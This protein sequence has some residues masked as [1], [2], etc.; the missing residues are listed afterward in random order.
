MREE[1][2][3]EKITTKISSFPRRINKRL[4]KENS[5]Q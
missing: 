2:K 4:K 5:K 3:I 1:K